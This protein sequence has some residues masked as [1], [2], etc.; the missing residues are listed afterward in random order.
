MALVDFNYIYSMSSS[1]RQQKF[2]RLIQKEL[3]D[4]FLRD[5]KGIIENTLISIVEVK[6]SPD[7]GVAKVFISMTLV[8]DRQA[9]L[10]QLNSHKGEIR[11]ALGARIRN[12]ARIIPELI[13]IIDEIEESALRMEELIN[14]LNIPKDDSES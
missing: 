2:G 1:I 10:M 12:Q 8:K 11:K 5:K 3:S 7:L 9:V 13:F 14:S 4:I 6:M